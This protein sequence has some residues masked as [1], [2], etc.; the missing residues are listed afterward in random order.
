MPNWKA[1]TFFIAFL[2]AA[3]A[4]AQLPTPNELYDTLEARGFRDPLAIWRVSMW[5]TGHL[6]SSICRNKNNLF[7]IKAGKDYKTFASWQE[8]VDA[9]KA[10]ED[11]KYEEYSA[12]KS[13]DYYDF[14]AWWGFKTGYSYSLSDVRYVQLIKKLAPPKGR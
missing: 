9:M 10:L 7:G 12:V 4:N 11:R 13:G 8:C 3:S 2:A 1:L 5:E 6:K 14:L